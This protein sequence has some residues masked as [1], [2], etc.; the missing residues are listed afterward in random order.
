MTPEKRAHVVERLTESP[1]ISNALEG[2]G[3]ILSIR[4]KKQLE[5]GDKVLLNLEQ[6]LT[7]TKSRGQSRQLQ[8]VHQSL[9]HAAL[10][11]VATKYGLQKHLRQLLNLG[12][13]TKLVRKGEKWW[14][15]KVRKRRRDAFS[16]EVKQ[17]VKGFY[18]DPSVSREVPCKREC[19]KVIDNGE[20]KT[21]AK[22]LM[23]MTMKDAFIEFKERNPDVKI[24]FTSFRK[25]KPPEVKRI[26]ETNKRSC[27]CRTCC[28][29]ALKS[30]ALQNF[31]KASEA[32][33]KISEGLIFDKRELSKI[34]L[35]PNP[36]SKCLE[37]SCTS[38]DVKIIQSY[39]GGIAKHCKQK[40]LNISWFKWEPIM[41]KKDGK[42][43]RIMSCIQKETSFEEFL[44][45]YVN[46]M[47]HYLSHIFRANWQ[48]DQMTLCLK[49][50]KDREVMSVM[51]FSEN[52]K[53]GFQNEPQDAFFDQNLVTIHPMM[54]YYKK[55]TEAKTVTYKHSI[56]GISD[57][58]K[59]DS[60]LVSRFEKEALQIVEKKVKVD[61]IHQWTDGCA[62][63]Y[64][65][66]NSFYDISKNSARLIRNYF[67]TSH[68]KNVCD[69]LGAIVKCS[70]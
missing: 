6:S 38:C 14:I 10:S 49:T 34:T 47:T 25:L 27:L 5:I 67:E 57:D 2:K 68:G 21:V 39:Y 4:T 18:T 51:D 37:R 42:E 45:D 7:E 1:S 41:I 20:K 55:K 56:I 23:V 53:C 43:K 13:N 61:K 59:H 64:K 36:K 26:T 17:N 70:C 30:E 44:N 50:L 8:T 62:A 24:G 58:L 22:H 69:G 12:K 63:Q 60:K 66:K 35:C 19:I 28:N 9:K 52:Y 31:T 48:H 32:L 29:A 33:Q 3:A 16:E 54:F 40:K 15:P 46:V 11:S 65:G